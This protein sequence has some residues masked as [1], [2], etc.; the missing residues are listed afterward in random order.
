MY[1][2][3]SSY[4]CACIYTYIQ[5]I[6]CM[7]ARVHKYIHIELAD[8]VLLRRTIPSHTYIHIPMYVHMHVCIH[9]HTCTNTYPHPHSIHNHTHTHTH[10]NRTYWHFLLRR[11]TTINLWLY[12]G[13]LHRISWV[14]RFPE[15]PQWALW[16]IG[17]LLPLLSPVC[18]CSSC[19]SSL[20]QL[21]GPQTLWVS[22][23]R[24]YTCRGETV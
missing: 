9:K 15:L 8:I 12:Y 14:W 6:A 11:N 5:N 22:R 2:Y 24:L 16:K 1:T 21:A 13:Y 10:M 17:L 23:T 19:W 3:Q 20:L 4:I 7:H 18:Q